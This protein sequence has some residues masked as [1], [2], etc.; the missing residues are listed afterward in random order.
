MLSVASRPP[1]DEDRPVTLTTV[2]LATGAI[3]EHCSA[4]SQAEV[5][6]GLRFGLVHRR[7]PFV[8]LTTLGR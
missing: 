7:Q 5:A 6:A 8:P 4:L 3:A 1:P 2:L